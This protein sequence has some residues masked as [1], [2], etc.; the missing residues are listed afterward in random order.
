MGHTVLQMRWIIYDKMAQFKRIAEGL[1]EPQRSA[2]QE[3]ISHLYQNISAISYAN[4]LPIDIED[5]LIFSMLVQEKV[6]RGYGL[7]DVTLKCFAL[8]VEEKAHNISQERKSKP[9]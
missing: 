3:L 6:K 8:M 5:S 1:R 4:P 2:A 7:E 9:A